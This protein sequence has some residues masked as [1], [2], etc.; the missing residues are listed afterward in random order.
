MLFGCADAEPDKK[1]AE[2]EGPRQLV[3]IGLF[4]EVPRD[5]PPFQ[6]PSDLEVVC[7][8]GDGYG[9][10]A[11]AGWPMFQ[12]FTGACNWAT[13]E[14]PLLDDIFEGELVRPR[15]WHFELS[16][17]EPAEGYAAIAIDGV[18]VWEYTVSI[19]TESALVDYAWTA[20]RDINAGTPLQ[21]HVNNHGSNSWHLAE[22]NA[23]PAEDE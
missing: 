3:D 12:V 10:E 20:D 18:I 8:A 16:A 11:L 15:V 6:P 17:P 19:P 2:P 22:L 14:Q 23:E 13:V 9:A 1:D 5:V 7:P 4:V 21:F